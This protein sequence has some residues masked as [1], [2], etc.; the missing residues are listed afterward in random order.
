MAA[1]FLFFM[2]MAKTVRK[3]FPVQGMGCAACVAMSSVCVVANSLR[4]A[5][6]SIPSVK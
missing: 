1:A 4:L 3:N 5:A 6:P 2:L